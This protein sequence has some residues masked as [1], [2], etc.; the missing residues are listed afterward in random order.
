MSGYAWFKVYSDGWL[1]GSIR[2]QMN[3]AQRGVWADLLALANRLRER[4]GYLR[5]APGLPLTRE[6]M[7]GIFKVNLELLNETIKICLNDV[8]TENNHHRLE[9][10]E[11]G[12][13]HITNFEIY[14]SDYVKKRFP[15]KPPKQRGEN[16]SHQE[17]PSKVKYPHQEKPPWER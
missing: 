7:A 17:K 1:E 10:L 11:D 5:Y 2:E 9:Q 8:N 16:Q 3:S 4:N 14:Q 12:T 15:A 13:L 6:E